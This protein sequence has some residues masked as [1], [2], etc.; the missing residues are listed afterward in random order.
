MSRLNIP[1]YMYVKPPFIVN[2]SPI[3]KNEFTPCVI[4]E[5]KKNKSAKIISFIICI[6][7]ITISLC[8]FNFFFYYWNVYMCRIESEIY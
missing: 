2:K 8:D 5:W 7:S 6:Y 3:I 4:I 1:L